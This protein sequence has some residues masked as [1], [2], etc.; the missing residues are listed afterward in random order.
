MVSPSLPF[1]LKQSNVH[2]PILNEDHVGDNQA[3]IWYADPETFSLRDIILLC[4]FVGYTE[5]AFNY[6]TLF[7][8]LRAIPCNLLIAFMHCYS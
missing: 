1:N 8:A 4:P 3:K 7:A 2:N 5:Y 6:P